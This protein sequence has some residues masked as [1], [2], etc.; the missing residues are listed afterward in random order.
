MTIMRHPDRPSDSTWTILSDFATGSAQLK[1]E[2]KTWLDRYAVRTLTAPQPGWVLLRGFAG[3]AGETDADRAL[4]NRRAGE[5]MKSLLA[6]P[7][8]D[9]RHIVVVDARGEDGPGPQEAD[10]SGRW[11]SVEVR[12]TP[13]RPAVARQ[14][15]VA[16]ALIERVL[17]RVWLIDRAEGED[18]GAAESSEPEVDE[19]GWTVFKRDEREMVE[20]PPVLRQ[21]HHAYRVV[22]IHVT[23]DAVTEEDAPKDRCVVHY[24]WGVAPTNVR[25]FNRS[26]PVQILTLAQAR[27]WMVNPAQFLL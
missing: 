26:E 15:A 27:A 24:V 11:R 12:I 10:D 18:A 20:M 6:N 25:L 8:I 23:Q 19:D 13:E 2:H 16:P 5:A 9:P 21:T 14:Q 1:P 4:S 7:L 17:E 3:G 22:E